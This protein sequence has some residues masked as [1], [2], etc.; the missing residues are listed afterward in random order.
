[1]GSKLELVK[2]CLWVR[3]LCCCWLLVAPLAAEAREWVPGQSAEQ[4]EQRLR[5]GRVVSVQSLESALPNWSGSNPYL[6]LQLEGGLKAVFRSEDEPWG[7]LAEL[8]GYRFDG[9][10]GTE[11][12]PP[13]VLRTLR[14]GEV[15]PW[16]WAGQERPGSLQLWAATGDRPLQPADLAAV[17]VICFVL[18]RYDNHSGNLLTGADGRPVLV[19]YESILDVQQVRYGDFSFVRRGGPVRGV[20]LPAT[21][22]FPFDRPLRL[23]DPSPEQIRT[24]L[25]PWWNQTWPQ[26]MEEL[27]RM[28]R[29]I[30]GRTV[31]YAIWD[32]RLWVQVRVSAR[33]PNFT[34]DPPPELCRRLG[35]LTP[36]L[37]QNLLG[38][39]FRSEHARLI[40]ERAAQVLAFADGT[41]RP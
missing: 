35:E 6:A 32:E 36:S 31:P 2:N 41:Q 28:L 17:E 26:G 38:Q 22:P 1:V 9:W 20:G 13:T 27:Y 15:S 12:T 18:G 8:A 11:L 4:I 10:F 16:P 7:S 29:G 21:E 5:S 40:C 3:L 14:R 19:D 37:A 39:P 34:P 25:G 23:V 33:H 24:C 30:P